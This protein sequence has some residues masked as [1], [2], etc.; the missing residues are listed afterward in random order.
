MAHLEKLFVPEG[1][2]ANPYHSLDS[3]VMYKSETATAEMREVKEVQPMKKDFHPI[4]TEIHV[5]ELRPIK[6]DPLKKQE[7]AQ[8]PKGNTW[9][10]RLMSEGTAIEN[11]HRETFREASM[12]SRRSHSASSRKIE[13]R[14]V[15]SS[16]P[17]MRSNMIRTV[18][19]RTGTYSG[20]SPGSS[21][22]G[23]L[24]PR[25]KVEFRRRDLSP[26]YQKE[27]TVGLIDGKCTCCPYGYHVDV[28]FMS[29]CDTLSNQSYLKQLKHIQREK[30][31]LRK[32][33]EVYLQDQ[34]QTEGHST[35]VNPMESRA[36]YQ[37]ST[38]NRLL[39]DID[40]SVGQTLTS[41]ESMMESSTGSQMYSDSGTATI[42]QREKPKKFNTFPKKT[43]RQAA[44]EL[45]TYNET[46]TAT[47]NNS[48]RRDSNS[49]LSS[50]STVELERIYPHSNQQGFSTTETST[51][52]SSNITSQHLAETMA[53]HMPQEG[54]AASAS[55]MTNISKDS[56]NA[57]REAMS[58]SLQRMKELEEQNKAI[59]VLQVRISVLKEEKRLLGLQMQAQ[60]HVNTV[61]RGVNTD[62][63]PPPRSPMSPPPLAPKPKVRMAAVGDHDVNES[64]LL[65]PELE[66]TH[67]YEKETLII[68]RA[69]QQSSLFNQDVSKPLTRT[70]G[71]GEGNVFDDSM[72]IHEKELRTVIIGQSERTGK[73]NV[74]IECRPSTRDV[75]I[76]YNFDTVEK[77]TTRSVGITTET[78]A[79]VTNVSFR[80]EEFTSAL[81]N[82]LAKNVRSVSVQVDNR[83]ESRHVGIQSTVSSWNLRSIGVGDASIDVEVRNPVAKRSVSVDA[84]PDRMNRS[85]NTDY[86]WRLDAF[87]NTVPQFTESETTQTEEVRKYN[88]TTMTERNVQYNVTCQTDM[89]IFAATDQVKNSGTNTEKVLTY[90]TGVNTILKPSMERGINTIHQRDTRNYGVNT[91]GPDIRNIGTGDG[92][93]EEENPEEEYL[94]EEEG[95]ET[96]TV[97]FTTMQDQEKTKSDKGYEIKREYSAP[98]H[99]SSSVE[100]R[101][102]IQSSQAHQMQRQDSSSSKSEDEQNTEILEEKVWRTSGDGQFTVTTV[103]TTRTFGGADGDGT[104]QTET[105]TVTGGPEVLGSDAAMIQKEVEQGRTSSTVTV[106]GGS[107]SDSTQAY[108]SSYMG[109]LSAGDSQT[110][111][112]YE[113]SSMSGQGSSAIERVLGSDVAEKVKRERELLDNGGLSSSQITSRYSSSSSSGGPAVI[114]SRYSSSSSSP[115]SAGLSLGA[116]LDQLAGSQDSGLSSSQSSSMSSVSRHTKIIREGDSSPTVTVREEFSTSQD[117]S[118]PSCTSETMTGSWMSDT[119]SMSGSLKSIMKKSSTDTGNQRRGITFADSVVGGETDDEEE[120]EVDSSN[121]EE[122]NGGVESGSRGTTSDSDSSYDEGCYDS[123]EGSI[124]YKCKDDEAIANGVPGAQ[125]FDQNIR[126]TFELDPAMKEACQTLAT[127]LEDSTLVQTKQLN[128]S[129]DIIQKEWFKVSSSKLADAHQNEDYLSCF[130]EISK[131]LLE[132]I[133]NMQDSNGNTAIHY[134]VSN[135]NFDIVS[136]LLDTGVCDLNKMNKAGYTAVIMATLASVQTQRQEEVVQRLFSMGNVN[137]KASK[138][139]Q[140]AL[141]FAVRQGRT[142]MVKMLLDTGAD[143]NIQDDEGSTALMCA[144]EHGHTEIVKM[145]LNTPGCDASIS[146]NDGSTALSI[147]MD[148]GHKDAGVLLYAHVN[149]GPGHSP[150]KLSK[151]HYKV[152][153][154]KSN[155]PQVGSQGKLQDPLL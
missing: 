81:R 148:A 151:H 149:F 14:E 38:T 88:S 116:E 34:E 87:T 132:Y 45:Q 47:F 10:R 86:G 97:Y 108:D 112:S 24:S 60:K 29:Y 105:K 70:V 119:G 3:R 118:L 101:S 113:S 26:S 128:N 91:V 39:D 83:Q 152:K 135:C 69:Q 21:P 25:D 120:E 46:F 27:Q 1:L 143:T 74:G 52:R 125:M 44:Q 17:E 13:T 40:N 99:S 104:V 85:V 15:N 55:N 131:R 20:S 92:I 30:R 137:T 136:L 80:S 146:D 90:N 110:R 147:A 5:T 145:L 6:L 31:K 19:S 107:V 111:H 43:G 114:T 102:A 7:I 42:Q 18:T 154:R 106:R 22:S 63:P 64:Y 72:H 2:P 121:E 41:I 51:T 56:L 9:E 77:P 94:F 89:K 95:V 138:D 32:S 124:V 82:A 59:P 144:A 68:D 115:S 8:A 141:M 127:Y 139:G 54:G 98:T 130:N 35:M 16:N 66:S 123:R 155:G 109:S 84:F 117:G 129:L 49:S 61:S 11:G 62:A 150:H 140:T 48:E 134:A 53:V 142:E 12:E 36:Y 153:H 37:E 76:S 65:Q 58:V 4:T 28:D 78:T 126:E 23:T 75:G 67:V 73:R 57:I 71:V 33:M 93:I 103:T 96:K 122:E 79:L 133:V 100:S 50:I